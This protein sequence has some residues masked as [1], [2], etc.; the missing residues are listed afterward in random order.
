VEGRTCVYLAKIIKIE[1]S[2]G[3]V[4]PVERQLLSLCIFLYEAQVLYVFFFTAVGI[5]M[6]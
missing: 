6:V 4:G 1:E 3:L 5:N 2:G